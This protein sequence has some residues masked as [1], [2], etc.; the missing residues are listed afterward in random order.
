MIIVS[1]FRNFS[2]GEA[3]DLDQN[4][5]ATAIRTLMD[6]IGEEEVERG[7]T[8]QIDLYFD[9]FAQCIKVSYF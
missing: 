2:N 9:K 7:I 4:T 3:E 1:I 6:R 5:A 8:F